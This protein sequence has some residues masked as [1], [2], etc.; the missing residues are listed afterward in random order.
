[1][2]ILVH[3][4]IHVCTHMGV[5]PTHS[6]THA[7]NTEKPGRYEWSKWLRSQVNLI[8]EKAVEIALLCPPSPSFT[9]ILLPENSYH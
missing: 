1:M 5:H 3:K 2:M 9:L 6:H 4:H 8:K 7:H